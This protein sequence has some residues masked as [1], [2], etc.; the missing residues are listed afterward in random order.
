MSPTTKYKAAWDGID[1][2]R[3]H[4]ASVGY[5]APVPAPTAETD[6]TT[7]TKKSGSGG[8]GEGSGG[9]A[10]KKRKDDGEGETQAGEEVTPKKKARKAKVKKE[11]QESGD[12]VGDPWS[13]DGESD[14]KEEVTGEL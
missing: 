14:V 11:V 1:K 2:A 12:A 6:V 8:G 3:K 5:V 7:P 9:S 10:G 4:L 13:K